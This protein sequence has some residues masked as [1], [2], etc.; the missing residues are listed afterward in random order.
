MALHVPGTET[1]AKRKDKD[2]IR[3]IQMGDE[4]LMLTWDETD[5]KV[6]GLEMRSLPAS[7]Y[8]KLREDEKV[9]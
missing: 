5:G 3:L 2:M 1:T 4:I 6:C 8:I 7:Y 9:H